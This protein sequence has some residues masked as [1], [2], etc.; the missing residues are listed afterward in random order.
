MGIVMLRHQGRLTV[1]RLLVAAVALAVPAASISTAAAASGIRH[2]AGQPRITPVLRANV[3]APAGIKA[4]SVGSAPLRVAN[5]SAYAAQ[6]AAA[7]AVAAR[8]NARA[9]A[10]A[11]TRAPLAP[12]LVRNWA[13]QRDTTDAPSDSTGAIGTT[14]YIELVNSK[15]AIYSRGSNTPTASGPLLKLTG[16]ATSACTDRV[17]D[18]QII[19]DPALNRFFYTTMDIG[20]GSPRGNLL[21]FGFS[22]TNTPTLSASS[23]CRFNVGFGSTIPDY[24]KLGDTKDFLLIGTNN[25]SGSGAFQGSTI[26]WISHPPSGTGCPAANTFKAGISGTLR[27]ASG[28]LAFTPVPANQT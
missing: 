14:R 7:N 3:P 11:P 12:S 21:D 1:S 6:K 24:P 22:K 2:H 4:R 20:S 23:W 28:T 19:W 27:N 5:P 17:F 13:G 15:A 25:F 26:F 16:C 18:V 9:S 10:S 8:L